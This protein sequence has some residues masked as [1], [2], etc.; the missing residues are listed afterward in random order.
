MY[1]ISETD[2]SLSKAV[3]SAYEKSLGPHHGYLLRKGATLAMKMIFKDKLILYKNFMGLGSKETIT[4][5]DREKVK[6]F[7]RIIKMI[8]DYVHNYLK[9]RNFLTLP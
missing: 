3:S 9:E 5:S 1:N 8:T 2:M 6:K 7:L 4:D